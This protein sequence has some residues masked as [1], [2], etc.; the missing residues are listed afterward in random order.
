MAARQST[1]GFSL[2]EALVASLILAVSIS[3]MFGLWAT[4]YKQINNGHIYEQASQIG[5]AELEQ[6]KIFGVANI[7]TG[8]YVSG[9]NTGTWSGTYDSVAGSWT[10]GGYSYYSLTGTR[11]ASSGAAGVYFKV[12]FTTADSDVLHSTGNAYTFDTTGKKA[13]TVSVQKTSD[14]SVI[15]TAGTNIVQ[16]GL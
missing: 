11:L 7:P 4:S 8:N 15:F 2:I 13:I 12:S 5:R 10:T 1:R 3:A 16:G 6:A 9:T 14:S